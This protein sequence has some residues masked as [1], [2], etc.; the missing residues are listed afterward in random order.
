MAYQKN[1]KYLK[2]KIFSVLNT[3]T[4]I[5]EL[6]GAAGRIFHANPPQAPQYPCIVYEILD[7][8]DGVYRET[9]IGGDVTRSNIRITI[10]DSDTATECSDNI[11]ARIKELIN[12]Q[13]TLDSTEIICYS[14]I[15]DSLIGPIKDF[16][17]Q[18]WITPVRYGVTWAMKP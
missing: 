16:E 1:I 17:S 9:N 4:T 7:D 12:G 18:V 15:R 8:K 6:L 3:D 11:E 5:L 13:R 2:K 10:Y 14:C